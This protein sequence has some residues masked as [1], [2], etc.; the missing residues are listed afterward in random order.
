MTRRRTGAVVLSAVA[1]AALGA[2]AIAS[3]TVFDGLESRIGGGDGGGDGGGGDVVVPPNTQAGFLTLAEGVKFCSNAFACPLLAQSTEFSIDVPVDSNHFSSCIG[4]VAGPLPKNRVGVASTAKFLTCAADATSCGGASGCMWYEVLDNAD[5]RC[6]DGGSPNG[7]CAEDG[8][9][10]YFCSSSPAVEHC[11]NAYFPGGFSCIKGADNFNYCAAPTCAGDQCSGTMLEFCGGTNKIYNGWDCAAGG[12]SCGF[13]STEGYVD[14]LTDGT[15]KR[16]NALSVGCAT[17]VATICD[18][19]Y[20]SHY[21]CNNYG[22]TCDQTSFPR[23][24]L[25][26]ETCTPFDP[27]VDVCSGSSITLCYG[28]QKTTFDCASV[29][30]TCVAGTNG[31]TDHCQ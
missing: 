17:G 1:T 13:D 11:T 4:W 31:Q 26:N 15:A 27:D 7:N 25:P 6:A 18:S 23:C 16:C 28:G 2:I 20:E 5:P 9:A 29:G 14:C 10:L 8:G 3:C 12:F 21:D 22:G 19:V 30:K 24:T